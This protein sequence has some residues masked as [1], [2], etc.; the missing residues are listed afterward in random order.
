[1]MHVCLGREREGGRGL[2]IKKFK[3]GVCAQ[4]GVLVFLKYKISAVCS[5]PTDRKKKYNTMK[6]GGGCRDPVVYQS[7]LWPSLPLYP[8]SSSLDAHGGATPPVATA[9]LTASAGGAG[10][11]GWDAGARATSSSSSSSD[12]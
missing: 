1:M 4:V 3:L 12:A 7:V 10:G 2:S 6:R 9:G 8:S 11:G 5:L